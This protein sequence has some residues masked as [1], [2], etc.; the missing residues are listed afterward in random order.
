MNKNFSSNKE[1]GIYVGQPARLLQEDCMRI[2]KDEGVI[3]EIFNDD[4]EGCSWDLVKE[5]IELAKQNHNHFTEK[6]NC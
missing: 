4:V 1:G 6:W 3:D 5:K 2:L